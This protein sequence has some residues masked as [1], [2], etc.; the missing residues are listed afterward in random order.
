MLKTFYIGVKALITK[1][2]K[3]LLMK[4]KGENG[5]DVWDVP[6]GRMDG[7]EKIVDTLHR[8]LKEEIPSI[9]DYKV[10]E[11]LYASRLEKDLRDGHGLIFLFYEVETEAFEVEL[12]EEHFEY[13][14]LDK[15]ELEEVANDKSVFMGEGFLNSARKALSN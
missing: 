2:D 10:G 4:K 3:V 9:K 6:G 7:D 8:E 15:N 13:V 1:G 11:L 14:W 12:S 5:N